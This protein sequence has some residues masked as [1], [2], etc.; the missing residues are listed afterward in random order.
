MVNDPCNKPECQDPG[1]C[2]NN[3]NCQNCQWNEDEWYCAGAGDQQGGFC[4]CLI[5]FTKNT[6]NAING[7][8][9]LAP[10]A[11]QGDDAYECM[12][13]MNAQDCFYDHQDVCN[14]FFSDGNS[15]YRKI[16]FKLVLE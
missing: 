13:P 14:Q 2:V 6:C 16:K 9:Q 5:S 15:P 11:E 10:W 4:E 3:P 7:T 8:W 12:V 1:S